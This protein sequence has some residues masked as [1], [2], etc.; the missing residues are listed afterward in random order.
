MPREREADE[1]G[2]SLESVTTSM[3]WMQEIGQTQREIA[4]DE[5]GGKNRGQIMKGQRGQ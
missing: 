3:C 2:Q 4:R 5:A 1:Y